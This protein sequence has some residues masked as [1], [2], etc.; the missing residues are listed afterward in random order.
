MKLL[1]LIIEKAIFRVDHVKYCR[2]NRRWVDGSS[3]PVISTNSFVFLSDVKASGKVYRIME[4]LW[5][6]LGNSLGHRPY[7]E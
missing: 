5:N 6:F 2:R 1:H 4:F 7:I 3:M